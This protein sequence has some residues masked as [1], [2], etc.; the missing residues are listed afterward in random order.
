MCATS[1]KRIGV[2]SLAGTER[3]TR[4]AHRHGT[5]RKFV[6]AQ[7]ER[8]RQAI[9]E[10]FAPPDA[11]QLAAPLPRV[12]EPWARRFVLMSPI[13][14]GSYRQVIEVLRDLFVASL[15]VGTIH[16][17]V[18]RAAQ[19]AAGIDRAHYLSRVR[20]GLHDEIFQS[21]QP[22]LASIDTAS[23]YYYLVQGVE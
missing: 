14:H 15:R 12:S 2:V 18:E 3:V 21:D 16:T 10:A 9:D 23:T 6:R 5:S 4:P 13:A 11:A 22:V 20:V 7:R 17:W 19:H 8:A 1:R